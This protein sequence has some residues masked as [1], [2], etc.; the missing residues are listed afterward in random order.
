MTTYTISKYDPVDENDT[1]MRME[2]VPVASGV[3]LFALRGHLRRLLSFGYDWDSS[4]LVE[5]DNGV[6]VQA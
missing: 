6:E 4:I 2:W 3:S 5:R 1:K